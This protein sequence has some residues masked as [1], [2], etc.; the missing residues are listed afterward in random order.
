M[1]SNKDSC[2]GYRLKLDSVNIFG[3]ANQLLS[4]PYKFSYNENFLLPYR[5]SYS[6]DYWG[7]YN[8][9]HNNSI[10]PKRIIEYIANGTS[11]V[12]EVGAA[13]REPNPDYMRACMLSK[14]YYPT[15]GYNSFEFEPHKFW[16]PEY[17]AP[18]VPI[19]VS[20]KVTA[21]PG[22]LTHIVKKRFYQTAPSQ[23]VTIQAFFKAF[24]GKS[25]TPPY[26]SIKRIMPGGLFK[27]L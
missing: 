23:T 2:Y 9:T 19:V 12:E 27:I 26:V 18:P 14:V 22:S 1:P 5:T 3:G 17:T 4:A 20:E 11:Y 24:Y 13:N 15:G 10:T 6:Q 25:D 21:T 7:F 16:D 8:G